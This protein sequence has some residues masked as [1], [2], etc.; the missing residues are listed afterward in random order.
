MSRLVA[1]AGPLSSAEVAQQFLNS[2]GRRQLSPAIISEVGI[3]QR[4]KE[5]HEALLVR[6]QQCCV[7]RVEQEGVEIGG[8]ERD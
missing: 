5:F 3:E 8:L 4:P 2:R 1:T 6:I 7:R